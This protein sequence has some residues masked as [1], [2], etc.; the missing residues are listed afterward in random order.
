MMCAA[1]LPAAPAPAVDTKRTALATTSAASTSSFPAPRAPASRDPHSA[2]SNARL[3]I[4]VDPASES[5]DAAGNAFPDV[6]TRK[7]RVKEN[8]PEAKKM[9][10]STLRQPGKTRRTAPGA[11][12]TSSFVPYVDTE[13]DAMPPPP[14]PAAKKARDAVPRTP[15]KNQIQPFVDE[16]PGTGVP[17]TPKFVPFQDEV[18]YCSVVWTVADFV[19]GRRAC[20]EYSS[21]RVSHEGQ[22][23]GYVRVLTDV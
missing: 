3:Q 14:V 13:A 9:A 16:E 6:G 4:F 11:A 17:S 1:A 2:P 12:A 20:N 7:T 23:G 22:E 5:A 10:G 8:V 21:S 18:L 15:S 19:L